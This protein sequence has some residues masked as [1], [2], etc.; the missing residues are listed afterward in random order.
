[1]SAAL[2]TSMLWLGDRASDAGGV[3]LLEGVGA[4][5]GQGHLAGDAD[6][7]HRVEVGIGQG[8]DHVGGGGTA[9]HHADPGAAGGVGVALGRVPRPLLVANQHVTEIGV[10]D[11]VVDG[12][13]GAAGIAEHHFHPFL[14]EALDE[15]LSPIQSYRRWSGCWVRHG[16]LLSLLG[17]RVGDG[18]G[19]DGEK[20]ES[21]PDGRLAH[22]DTSGRRRALHEYYDH[23][24]N[25]VDL[26]Q[27]PVPEGVGAVEHRVHST[28]FVGRGQRFLL[29]TWSDQDHRPPEVHHLFP[30]PDYRSPRRLGDDDWAGPPWSTIMKRLASAFRRAAPSPPAKRR[31]LA[32]VGGMALALPALALPA[33]ALPALLAVPAGA[34]TIPLPDEPVLLEPGSG[35]IS[36]V[37]V[38]VDGRPYLGAIVQLHEADERGDPGRRLRPAFT[39]VDGRYRMDDLPD[40][41]YVVVVEAPAGTAFDGPTSTETRTR[42]LGDGEAMDPIR[43]IVT[44]TSSAAALGTNQGAVERWSLQLIHVGH[45]LGQLEPSTVGLDLDGTATVVEIGGWA[46]VVAA[47]RQARPADAP[48]S[49]I[50]LHTGGVLGGSA[51]SHLFGGAT[52]A[53]LMGH[54]C[55]D[56]LAPS[57]EDRARPA[58]LDRFLGF[59]DDQACSPTVLG[60]G[61]EPEAGPAVATRPVGARTVGL[62]TVAA[63]ERADAAGPVDIDAVAAATTDHIDELTDQGVTAIVVL[64]G[65]GLTADR[66]L[67]A[68]LPEVDAVVGGGPGSLLGDLTDLGLPSAGAYPTELR[69]A[70]GDPVCLG[71]AGDRAQAVG[72]LAVELD[73]DGTV[74]A[75]GGR[76]QLLLGRHLVTSDGDPG[77]AVDARARL[78]REVAARPELT[79]VSVTRSP[80]TSKSDGDRSTT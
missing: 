48:E 67:A 61:S 65:L 70:D 53:D 75:C 10:D 20:R 52:D 40:G 15:G 66:V 62:V 56:Y 18:I 35:T 68:A 8:S 51:L 44:R 29:R 73:P 64:S 33:L 24:E 21:L 17:W 34:V 4:D 71:H 79:T 6:H 43:S 77:Q 7:G 47:I 2:V 1:M 28:S 69:N 11:G 57:P 80:A 31:R 63:P 26:G 38:D 41:C 72:H 39:G 23:G 59:L 36:G 22:V 13:D 76:I 14:L 27:R 74:V 60:P 78:E 50:T 32:A 9:G 45:H 46:R 12:E 58:E 16:C 30:R 54:A 42:C 25:T 37:V 5:G 3:A 19:W 55:F 49:T